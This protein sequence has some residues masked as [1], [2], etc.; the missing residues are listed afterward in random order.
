MY[1]SCR[2]F[3]LYISSDNIELHY[4]CVTHALQNSMLVCDSNLH[5]LCH[6][7]VSFSHLTKGSLIPAFLYSPVHSQPLSKIARKADIM[8]FVYIN[9]YP[10]VGKFTVAKE[11]M[12]VRS[13]PVPVSLVRLIL[14]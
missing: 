3:K 14:L 6:T 11:L 13:L 12:N 1:S 5:N 7:A 10:G 8:A 4:L 9:G 2:I